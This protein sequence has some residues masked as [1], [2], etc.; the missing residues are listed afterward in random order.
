MGGE[1]FSKPSQWKLCFG[2]QSFE[3][4]HNIISP[5]ISR[6]V[7]DEDI[8]ARATSKNNFDVGAQAKGNASVNAGVVDFWN[9]NKDSSEKEISAQGNISAFAGA[10]A[11]S[12]LQGEVVWD[13]KDNYGDVLKE[14]LTNF[15]G[16]W[17]DKLI[18]NIPE[19]WI[20]KAVNCFWYGKNTACRR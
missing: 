10:K 15:P 5:E 20:T 7:L 2:G 1:S 4:E 11:G 14:H 9:G 12:S 6:K 17:D 13:R 16:T 18:E 3:G 19:G 8:R